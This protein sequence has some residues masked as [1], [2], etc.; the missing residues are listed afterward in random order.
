[1]RISV[2]LCTYNGAHFLRAQLES[3]L[4]QTRVPDEI[5][6]CDD[7]STDETL[8]IANEAAVR[9]PRLVRILPAGPRLGT[10]GNF[11]R[12]LRACSGD[13]IAL[14]DQDDVWLP[15]KFERIEREMMTTPSLLGVFSNAALVDFELKPLGRT[16]WQ[17]IGYDGGGGARSPS[18][19]LFAELLRR[20]CVTGCTMAIA[21]SALDLVLPIDRRW[22][23]D[24]W[25]AAI[26]AAGGWLAPVDET[27]VLY[28][29]HSANQVGA[30]D[31][32]IAAR[33]AAAHARRS[34]EYDA[35]ATQWNVLA[36]HLEALRPSATGGSTALRS[37]AADARERAAFYSA[38]SAN[39]RQSLPTRAA[40]ALRE[41]IAGRY[42]R[43]AA[44]LPS[45][46]RDVL[47]ADGARDRV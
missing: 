6:L 36:D 15:Q 45:A 4:S 3:L 19:A 5:V 10:V 12:A 8:A 38:R 29:Q 7:G 47:S 2:A 42:A 44:G 32:G 26:L 13:L 14:S 35:A 39:G 17:W 11:E 30:G 43:Y 20:N 41:A 1:M 34:T 18:G 21:R 24:Y 31:R 16:Q 40:F 22:P 46:L 27:L 25:I 33:V 37:A 9:A 28:R 23:H